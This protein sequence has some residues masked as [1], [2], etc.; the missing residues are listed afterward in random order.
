[1]S[2]KQIEAFIPKAFEAIEKKKIAKNGE[3]PKQFNG[4]IASFGASIRQAGLLAT[5][6]FYANE[7][8]GAEEDRKKVVQA[9]E[10]IIGKSIVVDN[11][12]DKKIRTEVED[13]ATA[14]K[15]AVRTYKLT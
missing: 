15:L 1:M 5:V 7:N 9:I 8:S 14:L 3:I 12:V 2:R 4:Y 11:S 10:H 13:A 6:L